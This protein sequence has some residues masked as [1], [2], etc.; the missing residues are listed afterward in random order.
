M[1][2]VVL[3]WRH[4]RMW[5]WVW[6]RRSAESGGIGAA[7]SAKGRID[8]VQDLS[9]Y[10]IFNGKALA[11]NRSE[12][13]RLLRDVYT[14]ARFDEKERIREIIAQIRARR[15]QAVTGSG[16]ALAMGA[17]SQG[18]SPGAWLSFRLGGLAGIRGTKQL[19]QALKDPEEL[20]ALCDGLSAL[21]EKIR[22]QGREFLVIGEDE[23]LPAM[24]DDLKSC[25]RDASELSLITI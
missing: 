1:A 18:M 14:S 7:F 6:K 12:L 20:A 21:H 2:F 3:F 15:E 23:Q 4:C 17:A 22:N 8:D 5:R 24:V 13:T 9:G 11:R 25:W 10:I 19:D 16:H